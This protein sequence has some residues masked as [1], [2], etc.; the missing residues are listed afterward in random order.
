MFVL[1]PHAET[2]PNWFIWQVLLAKWCRNPHNAQ[3][4]HSRPW[5]L[6]YTIGALIASVHLTLKLDVPD[7]R[8][9]FGVK[10][11]TVMIYPIMTLQWWDTAYYMQILK[12]YLLFLFLF[13][14]NKWLF[15][16]F[17]RNE[18]LLNGTLEHDILLLINFVSCSRILKSF[19]CR[20]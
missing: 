16:L 11:A 17:G 18:V 14:G 15:L 20:C 13:F 1:D 5:C 10:T 2:R 19:S 8:I 6:E 4:S 7:V 9:V 12:G 3:S